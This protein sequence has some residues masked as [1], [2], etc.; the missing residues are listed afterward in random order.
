MSP[1]RTT[2][3][4]WVS[5]RNDLVA[6]SA[7]VDDHSR[8][9]EALVNL[10]STNLQRVFVVNGLR[11]DR[12]CNTTDHRP[13]PNPSSHLVI[14]WPGMTGDPNAHAAVASGRV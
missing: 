1:S 10:E 3:Q 6:Q 2:R 14:T 12:S 5:K 9:A 7:G 4:T 11:R 13:L 8:E